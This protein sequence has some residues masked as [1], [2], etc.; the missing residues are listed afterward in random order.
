[1]SRRKLRVLLQAIGEP[2]YYRHRPALSHARLRDFQN[3]LI[4]LSIAAYLHHNTIRPSRM[5][6]LQANQVSLRGHPFPLTA[7]ISFT[8]LLLLIWTERTRSAWHC[9]HDTTLTCPCAESPLGTTRT[10]CYSRP[11]IPLRHKS[12]YSR[13][14]SW[15]SS[16]I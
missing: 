11:A 16:W 6:R 15:R 5:V 12:S 8:R 2:A 1:M 14:S 3:V 4:K 10:T 13:S 7:L 9:W